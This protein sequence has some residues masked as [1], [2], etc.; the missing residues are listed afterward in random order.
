MKQREENLLAHLDGLKDPAPQKPGKHLFAI[1]HPKFGG[2]RKGSRNKRTKLA[3]AIIERLEQELGPVEPLEALLRIGANKRLPVVVRM[4][5]LKS[6]LPYIYPK[7]QSVDVNSTTP[8]GP[9]ETTV[10]VAAII[11]DPELAAAA[12]K[13]A[14]AALTP[15]RA[16]PAVVSQDEDDTND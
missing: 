13:L 16:L 6:I 2:R 15:K 9:A 4:D 8:D 14:L 5:A 12:Q 3:E 7:L 1:G 11:A 10:N